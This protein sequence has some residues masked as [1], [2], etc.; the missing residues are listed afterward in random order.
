MSM[1]EL[2]Y[3]ATDC[4]ERLAICASCPFLVK[5]KKCSKCG[6]F[7]RLKAKFK[8]CHCPEGKWPGEANH[9]VVDKRTNS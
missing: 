1:I 8:S 3:M 4:V 2:P 6:C 5:G 7:V 9:G